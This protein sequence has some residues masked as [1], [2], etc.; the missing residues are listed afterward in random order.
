RRSA[1]PAEPASASTPAIDLRLRKPTACPN[2]ADPFSAACQPPACATLIVAQFTQDLLTAADVCLRKP[3]LAACPVREEAPMNGVPA[4]RRGSPPQGPPTIHSHHRRACSG[5]GCRGCCVGLGG[6]SRL[7][8]LLL[9]SQHDATSSPPTF[10]PP[11]RD[12]GM[13]W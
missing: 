8:R 12:T 4:N 13:M 9:H 3:D 5:F 10:D 7:P 2:P 11:R 6:P 1:R